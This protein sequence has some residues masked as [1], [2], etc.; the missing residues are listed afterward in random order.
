MVKIDLSREEWELIMDLLEE[1]RVEL[2]TE[3]HHARVSEVRE[4]LR[5][6]RE[7]VEKTIRKIRTV[8]EEPLEMEA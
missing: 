8:L 4:D 5:K 1:E 6:K 7:L 3:I 2:P